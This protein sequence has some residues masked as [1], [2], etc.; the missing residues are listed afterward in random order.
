MTRI[1]KSAEAGREIIDRYLG[2]LKHWPVP[3]Q[4]LLIPT[5]EGE[6]FVIACGPED[7]PPL[8]LLHGSVA[9]SASW[10][11]DI[12]TWAE[13]FR[14]YAIDIIGDAGLSAPSRPPLNS[15]AHALW[16][17]DVLD[18]LA[19]KRASIAGVSL[20]GWLTL[21]YAIR[22]PGRVDNLVVVCPAGVGRIKIGVLF[23]AIPLQMLGRWGRRKAA[24]IVLGPAPSNLPPAAQKFMEFMQ[25]IERNFRVR[26]TKL[27][28]FSDQALAQLQIPVLAILGGKDALIDS[29]ETRSRLER[30]VP[31]V[32]IQY[33]PEAG[34]FIPPQT[35]RIAEFLCAHLPHASR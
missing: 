5:R 28:I 33:I 27:P 21:D 23:K 20:G 2:I 3:N 35:A 25:L 18:H 31:R 26:R 17:D 9:N 11:G 4:Q 22:R 29:D 30:N 13:H 8:V 34:H 10:I 32:E 19:V 16:L 12:R 7:A 24:E 15:E 14:I 6:T 1:W